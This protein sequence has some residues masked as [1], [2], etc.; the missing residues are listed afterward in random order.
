MLRYSIVDLAYKNYFESSNGSP[1]FIIESDSGIITAKPDLLPGLYRFN[2][3]VT[4]GKFIVYGLV[5]VD[6]S[7]IDQESLDHSV[8]IKLKRLNA[9][10]FVKNK[11]GVFYESLAREI[12]VST[13]S[14]RILSIQ[15]QNSGTNELVQR[16][17][18]HSFNSNNI[19]LSMDNEIAIDEDLDILFTVSR[20]ELLTNGYYRPTYIKQKIENSINSISTE[21][22]L[23]FNKIITLCCFYRSL[24][25][26]NINYV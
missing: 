4:D 2:A 23:F 20:G 18:K 5:T 8:S 25:S 13:T 1:R 16:K 3:S 22:G 10:N 12:G 21:T 6:V 17:K 9:Q 14:I 7:N 19:S 24:V 11:M 26:F 15:N